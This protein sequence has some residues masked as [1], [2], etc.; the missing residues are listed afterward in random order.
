MDRTEATLRK[1][2]AALPAPGYDLGILS[3]RGMYR[4]EAVPASRIPRML[5]HFKYHNA[6]GAHIYLRPTGESPYT[7]LDDPTAAILHRL[8]A[9]GYAPAAVIQTSPDSFPYLEALAPRSTRRLVLATTVRASTVKP[10]SD[11]DR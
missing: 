8:T 7:L 1:L 2:F 3:E 6:P 4:F 11:E 9:E 10:Y 5:P